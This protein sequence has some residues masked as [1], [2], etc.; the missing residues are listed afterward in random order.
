MTV[1]S[2]ITPGKYLPY[3][4]RFDAYIQA[5]G[6]SSCANDF[7][8]RLV[9]QL[10]PEGE[11]V[12]RMLRRNNTDGALFLR[13]EPDRLC[14]HQSTGHFML[15]EVKAWERPNAALEAVQ[16]LNNVRRMR[17]HKIAVLY[18]LVPPQG[19]FVVRDAASI[20]S[21]R[22]T[23]SASPQHVSNPPCLRLCEELGLAWPWTYAIPKS[24]GASDPYILVR[25]EEL[26][27]W[28]VLTD[29]ATIGAIEQVRRW[30]R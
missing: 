4:R 17:A 26:A 25:A 12:D 3:E 8:S 14:I 28:R 7:T 13:G 19:P 23:I 2:A 11:T 20:A 15:V 10:G 1:G 29:S 27:T 24:D 21:V 9:A 22:R 16:L 18:V 30:P 6:G 5:V